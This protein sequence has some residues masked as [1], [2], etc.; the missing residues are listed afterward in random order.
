[1]IPSTR[2]ERS[3]RIAQSKPRFEDRCHLQ[4]PENATDAGEGHWTSYGGETGDDVWGECVGQA[5]GCGKFE[6]DASCLGQEGCYL[7]LNCV[8]VEADCSEF[9]YG[10]TACASAPH[11]YSDTK[12]VGTTTLPGCWSYDTSCRHAIPDLEPCEA[13]GGTCHEANLCEGHPR[14]CSFLARSQA[15]CEA[16]QGCF[17]KS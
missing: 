17:W 4:R 12:Q 5:W 3:S 13:Y 2:F 7:V 14:D 15:E 11:C 1:L 6:D 16:Q 9:H 10:S 8:G